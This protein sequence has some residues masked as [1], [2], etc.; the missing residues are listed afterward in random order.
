[1]YVEK[2]RGAEHSEAFLRLVQ[3]LSD[4]SRLQTTT[5]A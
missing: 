3:K 1:M 4:F 5:N 2:V